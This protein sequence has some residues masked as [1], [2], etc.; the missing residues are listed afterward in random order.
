MSTATQGLGPPPPTPP[1]RSRLA[2]LWLAQLESNVLRTQLRFLMIR[3][4]E[5]MLWVRWHG[6]SRFIAI[7]SNI[8]WVCL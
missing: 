1:T 8:A 3:I 5:Y 2:G 7:D 4:S 6:G